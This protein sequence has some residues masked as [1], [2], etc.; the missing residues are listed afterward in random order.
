MSTNN[1]VLI[2]G[3]GMGCVFLFFFVLFFLHGDV[4][5]AYTLLDVMLCVACV[6]STWA[7]LQ[8]AAPSEASNA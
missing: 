1:K 3:A 2:V 7:T 4:M 5:Y 8:H 6:W